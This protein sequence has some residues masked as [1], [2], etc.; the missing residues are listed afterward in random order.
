[1]PWRSQGWNAAL[2][3][4]QAS[5][6]DGLGA[7]ALGDPRPQRTQSRGRSAAE[8]FSPT[9][10]E[11]V[12]RSVGRQL[13]AIRLCFIVTHSNLKS[14]KGGHQPPRSSMSTISASLLKQTDPKSPQP[15]S[16]PVS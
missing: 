14:K 10:K 8:T 1:M 6:G 2:S 11:V 15:F 12:K 7:G 13:T 16:A 3:K 5:H 9:A 4:V